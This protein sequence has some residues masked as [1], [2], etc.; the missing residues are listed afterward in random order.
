MIYT[1]VAIR[2]QQQE[3]ERLPPQHAQDSAGEGGAGGAQ[4]LHLRPRHVHQ[5]LPPPTPE[6]QTSREGAAVAEKGRGRVGSRVFHFFC[7]CF[8]ARRFFR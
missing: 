2:P 4:A 5:G 6:S 3:E 8:F 1:G 7:L